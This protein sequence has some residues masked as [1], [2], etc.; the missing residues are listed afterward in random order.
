MNKEYHVCMENMLNRA[1]EC[2]RQLS[3]LYTIDESHAVKHSMDVFNY[4]KQY[5]HRY[6]H[7][8]PY[9]VKQQPVLYAAAI[10]HD[11]CDHKYI[12]EADGLRAIHSYMEAF[13]TPEEFNMMS[14]IMTTISYS[15]VKK[16]GFPILGEW[17]FA[18]HIVRE[19]D[20]LTSYDFDRCVIYGMYRESLPY[21]DAFIRARTLYNNRVLQYIKDGAFITEYGL[22]KAH[23]LHGKAIMMPIN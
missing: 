6:I 18:Y 4:T 1:F 21:T 12:A 13:F 7:Y 23:E 8:H 19:S 22:S 2:V 11:M 14:I 15:K 10:L 9:L 16:N 17:Q 5:Y 20:L 3:V